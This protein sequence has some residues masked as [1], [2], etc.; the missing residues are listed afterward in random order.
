MV[1]P[2]KPNTVN[3][4]IRKFGFPFVYVW[5]PQFFGGSHWIC[6]STKALTLSDSDLCFTSNK[7]PI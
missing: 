3:P 7:K 2:S 5:D 4:K 1:D 6:I